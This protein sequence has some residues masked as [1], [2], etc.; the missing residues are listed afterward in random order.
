ML[1]TCCNFSLNKVADIRSVRRF[2]LTT[3]MQRTYAGTAADPN[4]ARRGR[5][6]V[7]FIVFRP[8]TNAHAF[9]HAA[10]ISGRKRSSVGK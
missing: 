4:G 6:V 3:V 9:A 5:H 2:C 10:A 7:Q 1:S 8:R